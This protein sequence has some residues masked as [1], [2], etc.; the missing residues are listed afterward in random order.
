MGTAW[1]VADAA[2]FLAS[3]EADLIAGVDLLVGGGGALAIGH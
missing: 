1:N 3:D 2:L